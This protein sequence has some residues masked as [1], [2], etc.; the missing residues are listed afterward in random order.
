MSSRIRTVSYTHLDVYKRQGNALVVGEIDDAGNARMHKGAVTDHRDGMLCGLFTQDMGKAVG[1]ANR[2]AHAH[3]GVNGV[4]RRGI[5][6][7]VTCLL[8]TS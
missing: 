2:R 5:A 6:Q 1:H 4:Q 8:Y 3:H 7:G